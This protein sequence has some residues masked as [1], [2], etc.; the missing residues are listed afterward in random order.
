MKKA[1]KHI[2]SLSIILSLIFSLSGINVKYHH[3]NMMHRTDLALVFDATSNNDACSSCSLEKANTSKC[4]IKNN[5]GLSNIVS[6]VQNSEP[7]YTHQCCNNKTFTILGNY[8]LINYTENFNLYPENNH[9]FH[10][11]LPSTI[12]AY[13]NIITPKEIPIEIVHRKYGP[14]FLHLISQMRA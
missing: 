8:N 3:C 11:N 5:I 9:L 6:K 2:V 1:L 14:P 4:N 12:F 10:F 13:S 7:K